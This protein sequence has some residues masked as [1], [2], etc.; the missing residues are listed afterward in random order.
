MSVETR[1]VDLY[2]ALASA[3]THNSEFSILSFQFDRQ[4]PNF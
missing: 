2:S 1:R 3:I 4:V